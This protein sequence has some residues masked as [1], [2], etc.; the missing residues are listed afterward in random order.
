MNDSY[1]ER[2]V[3]ILDGNVKYLICLEGYALAFFF[4]LHVASTQNIINNVKT[5]LKPSLKP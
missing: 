5:K 1:G 3:H 2:N 4:S